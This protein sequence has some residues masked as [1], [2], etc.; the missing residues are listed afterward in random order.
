MAVESASTA[1]PESPVTLQFKQPEVAKYVEDC[2]RAGLFPSVG[3]L[4]EEAVRRMMMDAEAVDRLT[5][6]DETALA[7]ARAEVERGEGIDFDVFATELRRK[8]GIK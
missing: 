8:Y 4:L 6:E 2:I 3:V 5:P 1:Q 7:E